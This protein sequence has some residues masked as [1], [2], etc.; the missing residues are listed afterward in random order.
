[1]ALAFC[2]V[3]FFIILWYF[4]TVYSCFFLPLMGKLAALMLH[5]WCL[6]PAEGGGLEEEFLF[7][8]H[9]LLLLPPKKTHTS[10]TADLPRRCQDTVPSLSPPPCARRT[11]RTH[12]CL[13]RGCGPRCAPSQRL[14]LEMFYAY[15][16][17]PD[18]RHD[19]KCRDAGRCVDL[20]G[21]GVAP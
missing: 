6:D 2:G 12:L 10:S 21:E 8:S 11:P 3:I 9:C 5:C 17:R 4:C 20:G 18:T 19:H 14:R 1:M 16:R 13:T 15:T 7:S